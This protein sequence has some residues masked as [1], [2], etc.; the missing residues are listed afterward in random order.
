MKG[1]TLDTAILAVVMGR[2]AAKQHAN[3]WAVGTA[4]PEGQ[5]LYRIELPKD[6]PPDVERA[7][8]EG[9]L[10]ALLGPDA[11]LTF[12][13]AAGGMVPVAAGRVG[14]CI[15]TYPDCRP[16]PAWLLPTDVEA[17]YCGRGENGPRFKVDGE[18]LAREF[19]RV[20]WAE[21]TANLTAGTRCRI[22]CHAGHLMDWQVI[23]G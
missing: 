22:R 4:Q 23:G 1:T 10:R 12:G 13:S 17:T 19:R 20:P 18:T 16:L 5:V 2:L 3:V 21:M 15:A 14:H 9:Y 8:V 7:T 11:V 6:L